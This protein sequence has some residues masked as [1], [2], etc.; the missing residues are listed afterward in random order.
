[1]IRMRRLTR[2]DFVQDGVE[3]IMTRLRDGMSYTRYMELY[4]AVYNY[5]V[6]S[7]MNTGD[8]NQP[9]GLGVGG[10]SGANLMGADLYKALQNYFGE[11]L[12]GV[13]QKA[14]SEHL[15]DDDLLRYYTDEWKRYTVGAQYVNRLFTYLNRHWIKREKDEGRRNIYPVYTV[16]D[17]NVMF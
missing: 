17:Q 9:L 6:S 11:H 13:Q 5:C 8:G 14:I 10:R 7:R 1:M 16:R 15:V 2:A 3:L 4:T 12:K